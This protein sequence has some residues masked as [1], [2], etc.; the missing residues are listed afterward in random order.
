MNR[1]IKPERP[2]RSPIFWHA[3][4]RWAKKIHGRFVY[5]GRGTHEEPLAEYT[6]P[7]GGG[8]CPH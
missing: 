6:R 1:P 2:P 5:F 4:G 7:T 8:S 3:T